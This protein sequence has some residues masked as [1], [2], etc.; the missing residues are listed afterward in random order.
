MSRLLADQPSTPASRIRFWVDYVVR[1]G[2]SSHLRSE[3]ARRLNW[4]QYWSLDVAVCLLATLALIGFSVYRLLRV[5][6]SVVA[7][8]ALKAVRV[9]Q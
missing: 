8:A 9:S 4:F 7:G 2:G 5:A 3:P 6:V 1:H